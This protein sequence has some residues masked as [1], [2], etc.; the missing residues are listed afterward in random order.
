MRFKKW[1]TLKH[2]D[3]PFDIVSPQRAPTGNNVLVLQGGA[4]IARNYPREVE[5]KVGRAATRLHFLGAAGWGY[6]LGPKDAPVMKITVHYAGGATE[7]I[8]LRNGVEIADYVAK[9]DVPGS[10]ALDNLDQLLNNGRQV[11]YFAKSLT[12]RGVIEKLT[13]SQ[14]QQRSR[15]DAWLRSRRKSVKERRPPARL[16]S[17]SISPAAPLI[18]VGCRSQDAHHRWRIEP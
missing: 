10:E 8:V 14:L 3:V 6:P 11:R 18:P 9:I 13:I 7:D 2:R 5:V 1:G 4:G 17:S 12:K 16:G 15:A